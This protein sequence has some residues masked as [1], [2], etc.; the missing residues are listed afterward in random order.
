MRTNKIRHQPFT[1]FNSIHI[2]Y[3]YSEHLYYN[4]LQGENATLSQCDSDDIKNI[5]I[6]MKY[7]HQLKFKRS[8]RIFF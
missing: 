7:F 6:A 8:G 4:N 1:L 5:K 3:K 2:C